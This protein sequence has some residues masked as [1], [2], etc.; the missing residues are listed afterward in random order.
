[1]NHSNSAP[2]EHTFVRTADGHRLGVTRAGLANCPRTLLLLHGACEHS[3]RYL[4]HAQTCLNRGWNFATFDWRGHG[5]SSGQRT[6][7]NDEAE[8]LDDLATV[9]QALGLDSQR[10]LL[11][12]H[13][14]GGL[15]A[16]RALQTGRVNPTACALT[17]PLLRIAA[18]VPAWKLWLGRVARRV[19]PRLRFPVTY[20]AGD[21]T[22]DLQVR[23]DRLLDPL[24]S[25]SI[26]A[27]W[28]FAMRA[29][30]AHAQ[31]HPAD[32][33]VPL[34]VLQAGDDRVVSCQAAVD[35][36]GRLAAGDHHLD[37]Y[38]QHRHELLHEVDREAI[39]HAILT[40]AD[41]RVA[42]T[43]VPPDRPH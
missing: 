2:V 4:Q 16:L 39:L 19:S 25:S 17:S 36:V 18:P 38:P 7:V 32:V 28:F 12:A 6:H 34:L 20:Q 10:V 8:Y 15:L 9:W 43:T 27:G 21:L 35:F 3:G 23:E 29:A 41:P 14:M 31:E 40:W 22:R 26:T 1:M 13:S 30:M 11:L 24:I 33:T 5:T 42:G 37:M